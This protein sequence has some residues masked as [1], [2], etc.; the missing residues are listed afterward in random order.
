MAGTHVAALPRGR[1]EL[2]RPA[3]LFDALAARLTACF[4]FQRSAIGVQARGLQSLLEQLPKPK[5]DAGG[6]QPVVRLLFEHT[7]R[8]LRIV[9]VR[10]GILLAKT[11]G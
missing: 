2:H 3:H 8:L 6:T 1:G 10:D 5:D 7:V 9:P 11:V 4:G